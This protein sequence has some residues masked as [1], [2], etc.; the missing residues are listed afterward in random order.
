MNLF[1]AIYTRRTI[2]DFTAQPVPD[3][4]LHKALDAGRWAQNHRMTEPWRFYILGP[5]TKQAV[6]AISGDVLVQTAKAD[7]ATLAKMR[8]DQEDKILGK[9]RI[10]AVTCRLCGDKE[11]E[12]EDYAAVA[13]AVQNVQLAAWGLGLGMQ[14]GSSRFTTAPETYTLL[15]VDP[16]K[17]MIVGLLY[18]GFPAAVPAAKPRKSL[19]EIV[20]TLP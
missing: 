11:I 7:A 4:L 8:A 5:Q 19:G 20:R 14:W 10:V 9:P 1:D 12:Q 15:G 3:E 18:F 2:K 16:A 17:E 6:A 13:C